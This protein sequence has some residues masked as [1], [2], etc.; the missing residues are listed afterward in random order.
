MEDIALMRAMNNNAYRFSVAWPRVI[1]DGDGKINPRGLNYYDRVVD[2]LLEAGIMP[3]ITLYHW[4][5]PQAL[6]D[7]GGWATRATVDAYVRYVEA[8]VKRMGDRVKQ[9][10]THNEPWCVSILSHQIGEHAPGLRD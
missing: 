9:G 8:T 3:F 6:H 2:A 10:M 1:P 7:K 5:L 4:D